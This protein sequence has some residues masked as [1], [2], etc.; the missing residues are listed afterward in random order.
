MSI[1]TTRTPLFAADW[2]VDGEYREETVGMLKSGKES[3]VSLIARIAGG[4]TSDNIG[5]REAS[6]V[7]YS[8]GER[9]V[10]Y[11]AEKRFKS[12]L[13]RG[14]QGDTAYRED[15]YRGP[16]GAR[17]LR[18]I[19]RKRAAGHALLEGSWMGHEWEALNELYEAGVTVPP[20]VGRIEV[21][22]RASRTTRVEAAEG[23]YRMAFIGDAPV[24]A[25]RLSAVRLAPDEAE[26]VWRLMLVEIALMLRAE[27]VHGDLSAYNV[28]YWRERP[29]LIDFSQTVHVVTH[30]GARQL[31]RRDV[32]RLAAY[33]Q[34]QGI[35]ASVDRAWDRVDAERAL[36]GRLR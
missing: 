22:E 26:R 15:R 36:D 27:R 30:T 11:I 19:R 7:V 2:L 32:E 8:R 33:F 20:P 5:G 13:F 31:L 17:V 23:G 34:R 25:P 29:V 18:G 9:R 12:R 28:L 16:G 6:A 24:A 3:E 35:A 21:T 14:F 1:S 4:R 10:S